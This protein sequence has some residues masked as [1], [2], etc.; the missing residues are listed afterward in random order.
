MKEINTGSFVSIIIPVFNEGSNIFPVIST[1][2]F[3]IKREFEIIIVYDSE[4][5]TTLNTLQYI[6]QQNSNILL[7][8]NEFGVGGINA[9]K[10]GINYAKYEYVMVW[11]SYHIDPDGKINDMLNIMDKGADLVSANRFCSNLSHGRGKRFKNII[12]KLG[13]L[14][15]KIITHGILSDAT[16]SIKIF[17]TTKLKNIIKEQNSLTGW[18]IIAEWTIKFIINGYVVKQIDFHENNL[19][20]MYSKSNFEL[21]TQIKSYIACLFFAVKNRNKIRINIKY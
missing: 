16:T 17:R 14:L 19:Q 3:T 18:S 13:N 7:K 2:I 11:M 6:K 1:L 12:S 15:F 9:V 10:T 5:D 8:H 21:K 4:E 20:F